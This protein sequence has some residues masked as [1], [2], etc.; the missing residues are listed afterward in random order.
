L[1]FSTRLPVAGAFIAFS[2]HHEPRPGDIPL[3]GTVKASNRELQNHF[4]FAQDIIYLT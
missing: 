4:G 2:D 3:S 1:R